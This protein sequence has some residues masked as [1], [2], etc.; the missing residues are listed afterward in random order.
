[1]N[2]F[3]N[4]PFYILGLPIKSNREEIVSVADDKAFFDDEKDYDTV[5][6][7]LLSP[8]KRVKYEWTWIG[9]YNDNIIE[10]INNEKEIEIK[11]NEDNFDYITINLYNL[12]LVNERN[13]IIYYV[14]R[15]IEGLERIT[16]NKIGDKINNLRKK[17]SFRELSKKE[18]DEG[19]FYLREISIEN[20]KNKLNN[21]ND[22]KILANVYF[23]II[24]HCINNEWTGPIVYDLLETYEDDYMDLIK[25]YD[26]NYDFDIFNYDKQD[27]IDIKDTLKLYFLYATPMFYSEKVFK[28]KFDNG[29]YIIN[30][31]Y[32]IVEF[33][34]FKDMTNVKS[35][36][37]LFNFFK[38][39]YAFLMKYNKDLYDEYIKINS[40][41]EKFDGN[42]DIFIFNNILTKN[43]DYCQI[44]DQLNNL[45]NENLEEKNRKIIIDKFRETLLDK[46]KSFTKDEVKNWV[47]YIFRNFKEDYKENVFLNEFINVYKNYAFRSFDKN[48]EK[49]K[50]YIT[51][52]KNFNEGYNLRNICF[53][54]TKLIKLYEPL[55]ILNISKENIDVLKDLLLDLGKFYFKEKGLERKLIKLVKYMKEKFFYD[56]EFLNSFSMDIKREFE[57]TSYIIKYRD[58]F[59]KIKN[60]NENDRIS[61]SFLIDYLTFINE[62]K[63]KNI[64]KEINDNKKPNI[65]EICRL[66]DVNNLYNPLKMAIQE[67]FNNLWVNM[68]NINKNAIMIGYLHELKCRN[69]IGKKKYLDE[70]FFDYVADIKEKIFCLKEIIDNKIEFLRNKNN[71]RK[72]INEYNT[73]FVLLKELEKIYRPY[74]YGVF[75]GYKETLPCFREIFYEAQYFLYFLRKDNIDLAY[76]YYIYFINLPRKIYPTACWNEFIW[77]NMYLK[78][79]YEELIKENKTEYKE[80]K[81]IFSKIEK[82]NFDSDIL[83]N[84]KLINELEEKINF[85]DNF[86]ENYNELN[87]KIIE[88]IKTKFSKM[89]NKKDL[90]LELK[91]NEFIFKYLSP[92]YEKEI[93]L[94]VES[95]EKNILDIEKFSKNKFFIENITEGILN[96]K[97][98]V[99][100]V[101]KNHKGFLNKLVAYSK[102][103]MNNNYK[104]GKKMCEFLNI[105][106]PNEVNIEVKDSIWEAIFK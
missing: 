22:K 47:S 46:L 98:L 57:K 27:L 5:R 39:N 23:H 36:L 84:G 105:T 60:F 68:Y 101:I 25:K 52:E 67:A 89:E 77:D 106:F 80:I 55:F 79:R 74:A 10:N 9:N 21:I 42:I 66:E 8:V 13:K 65:L 16:Q 99:E 30:S 63:T 92:I 34:L 61:V 73:L 29:D 40:K 72:Y 44:I 38:K 64:L 6:D 97:N 11:F 85:I 33:L 17:A 71:V 86:V 51:K 24:N 15:I 104:V 91:N 81:E 45:W 49:I 93:I 82:N 103:L 54:S 58:L 26:I 59:D 35:G 43:N 18:I 37:S 1:M 31:L 62:T 102:N 83:L 96:W 100:P 95:I 70:L 76:E 78:N 53:Y 7:T 56:S 3:T 48:L 50:Y 28:K 94:K 90:L 87:E 32:N 4:N 41:V 88:V 75:L 20:I 19:Y 12:S 14:S 2:F 69:L